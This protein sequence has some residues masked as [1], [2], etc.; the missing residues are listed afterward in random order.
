M[1]NKHFE[2]FDKL[3]IDAL[4]AEAPAI[5]EE[6]L[7]RSLQDTLPFD[8]EELLRRLGEDAIKGEV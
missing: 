4:D 8:T 6:E 1:G 2:W 3:D 5:T 7:E